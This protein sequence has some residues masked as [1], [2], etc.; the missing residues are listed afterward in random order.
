MR[1]F[2]VE[3][4]IFS[5]LYLT[6]MSRFFCNFVNRAETIPKNR[7]KPVVLLTN[8]F[9]TGDFKIM[10]DNKHNKSFFK[11]D[12][13]SL[14]TNQYEPISTEPYGSL[15]LYFIFNLCFSGEK[16]S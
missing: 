7:K 5:E 11:C 8:P 12:D 10:N 6:H 4:C 16:I 13:I 2:L 3:N 9:W 1:Y 15:I 14:L